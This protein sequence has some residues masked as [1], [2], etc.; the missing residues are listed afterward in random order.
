MR[1]WIAVL[2]PVLLG[3]GWLICLFSRLLSPA[4]ALANRD[5]PVFHLPLRSAFR[6][7]AAHGLPVW[8]PWLHGGQPVLSNPS[9]GAFYPP[10]WL[11]F[12]ASPA[13]AL[14][15]M[16]L[17]HAAVAFAGAWRLARH[18]GCGRAAA[19]LAA[20]GYTGSSAF[21]SLL[22]AYTLFGSMA[23]FPWAIAWGDEA[24]R[25][26]EP[27]RWWRPALL[28]GGALGLQ[29]LNGEPSTVVIS[30]LAL[31]AVAASA[32]GRRLASL[33]RVLVPLA[34]A[35]A[36]SAVQLLPTLGRLADSP[37]KDVSAKVATV[38]SMRPTRL[39]EVVFPRF[40]GDPMRVDS[41]LFLGWK[42]HDRGYPY[43]E[44]LYPGLLLAVLGLAALLRWRIPRRAAWILCIAGGILLAAGRYNPLYEALRKIFPVLAVLRFPEKFILLT[45]FALGF[46]GVLGWQRLLDDRDAGRRD[47][48][49][50]P[51]ALALI[52]LGTA[53]VFATLIAVEPRAASWFVYSQSAPN[54]PL[55]IRTLALRHLFLESWVSVLAA[56]GV[57]FLLLLCRWR[58]PPRRL[59]EGLALLLLS[60]DLWH[61]GHRLL[62]TIESSVYRDPPLL[63]KAL[64]P[65]QN[66]IFV[67]EPPKGSPDLIW[68]GGDPQSRI[69]RT[70]A[71]MLSPY[72]GL[73]WN[74]PYAFDIDF[75]MM[76]TG[77]GR[78]AENI[79]GV[80]VKDTEMT[81]RYLGVWNV[82]SLVRPLTAQEKKV[83]LRD[84]RGLPRKI[85][86]NPFALPRYRFVPRVTFHPSHE[87]AL[88]AARGRRWRIAHD[89]QCVLPGRRRPGLAYRRPP[90]LLD[91]LDEANRTTARYRAEEGAF[92]VFAT[93]F[94]RGWEALVDGKPVPAYPT[95]ACQIGVELPPG[96]HRLVLEYRDPLVLPGAAVT[97]VSLI[98]GTAALVWLG[99]QRSPT[100]PEST[101]ESA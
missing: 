65:L 82:G 68:K 51:L 86:K 95:A 32:A 18:F 62:R 67:Q 50:L 5:I 2:S 40:F 26:P 24:L 1:R 84:P 31:L 59:L 52:V 78:K 17:F 30:G 3:V 99:R 96:E 45:V 14:N 88:A 66:R 61:Y 55:E 90:K 13:Y 12:V 85:E 6:D 11:I 92:L 83:I 72:A 98:L 42:V 23:W 20:V 80:E 74:V 53:L 25:T 47:S 35:V 10:S 21:L 76:L 79:L 91:V 28:S 93:T 100:S 71:A 39:V 75:E 46:A 38:W 43:V 4:L 101:M 16:V 77:W 81:Y 48:A 56:A 41:G 8:N 34:F 89:E 70:Y 49:D 37:R 19:A 9:Y 15:L 94:D 63:L 58:R 69:A 33:P 64:Q 36:L 57:S 60:A 7:L 54:T 97:L 29:L 22:S 44:S 27:R 87:A 73:M